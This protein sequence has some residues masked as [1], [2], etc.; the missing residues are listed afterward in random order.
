[1]EELV[2]SVHQT[3]EGGGANRGCHRHSWHPTLLIDSVTWCHQPGYWSA[4]NTMV[5]DHWS[6]GWRDGGTEGRRDGG[7]MRWWER[8]TVGWL[9][10]G[11]VGYPVSQA[12]SPGE[13]D[14][15]SQQTQYLCLLR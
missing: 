3:Q 10:V 13:A 15:L 2:H 7:M 6:E 4:G 9:M 8:W 5:T 14:P 11:G 1:M 12:P